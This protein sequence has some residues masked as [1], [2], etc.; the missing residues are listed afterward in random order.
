MS[1][2]DHIAIS[3]LF[4]PILFWNIYTIL[5]YIAHTLFLKTIHKNKVKRKE[6]N[7]DFFSRS[8][9]S[10]LLSSVMLSRNFWYIIHYF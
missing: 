4:F 5:S 8:S 7:Q 6:K 9:F 2:T 10:I 1:E 3:F